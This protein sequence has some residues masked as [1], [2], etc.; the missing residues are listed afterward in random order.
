MN[1]RLLRTVS[2]GGDVRSLR[3][4]MMPLFASSTLVMS[5]LIMLRLTAPD[6]RELLT[7]KRD[8]EEEQRRV[9]DDMEPREPTRMLLSQGTQR[10]SRIKKIKKTATGTISKQSNTN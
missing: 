5:P 4:F 8:I 3:T 2:L 7:Q 1:Q 10:I 9:Y 6:A